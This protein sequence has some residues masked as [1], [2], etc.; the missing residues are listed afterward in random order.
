ML[1]HQLTKCFRG[2]DQVASVS[3]RS[4]GLGIGLQWQFHGL[5]ANLL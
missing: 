4:I 3:L 5:D 1:E 2:P